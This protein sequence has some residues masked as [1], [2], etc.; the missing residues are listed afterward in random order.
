[1]FGMKQVQ[2]GTLPL[3]IGIGGF[4]VL[5]SFLFPHQSQKGIQRLDN[6]DEF[7]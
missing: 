4:V 2:I 7:N 3:M 6:K 1:M 5:I